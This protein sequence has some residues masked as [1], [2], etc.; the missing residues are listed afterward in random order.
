MSRIMNILL[1]NEL[2]LRTT[3]SSLALHH[4]THILYLLN[5]EPS[6]PF[7]C[8]QNHKSAVHLSAHRF[9]LMNRQRDSIGMDSIDEI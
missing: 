7:P 3:V 9:Y 8:L 5:N 1:E 6:Q 4:T 2:V